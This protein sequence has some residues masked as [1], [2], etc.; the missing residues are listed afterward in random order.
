MKNLYVLY[1]T[2]A[3]V[4][5]FIVLCFIALCSYCIFFQVELC[6]NTALSGDRIFST[7]VYF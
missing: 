1:V 5:H 3:G 7:K 4:P 2:C 6:G